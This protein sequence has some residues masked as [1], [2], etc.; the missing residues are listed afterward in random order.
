[1]KKLINAIKNLNQMQKEKTRLNKEFKITE[2]VFDE[3]KINS[4]LNEKQKKIA[5]EFLDTAQ[6]YYKDAKYYQEKGDVFSS[7]GCLNYAHGWLDAGLKAGLF[8]KK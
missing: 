3:I 7:M 2:K 4:K 6:R 8:V 5:N 1:M